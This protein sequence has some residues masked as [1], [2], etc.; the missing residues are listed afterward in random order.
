MIQTGTRAFWRATLALSIGA[1][2]VFAN[3]YFIQPLLPIFTNEFHIPPVTA[4]LSM[5]VT[6]FSLGVSLL[7]FGPLSDA[8]GR[9]KSC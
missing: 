7:F 2:L 3:L 4:S 9:K 1:F 6:T 5:S 8:L